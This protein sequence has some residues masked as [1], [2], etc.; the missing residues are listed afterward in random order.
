MVLLQEF[1]SQIADLC[2]EYCVSSVVMELLQ[3]DSPEAQLIALRSLHLV[4]TS[5]P[6]HVAASLDLQTGTL[7]RSSSLAVGS[8]TGSSMSGGTANRRMGKVNGVGVGALSWQRWHPCGWH[9]L[10]LPPSFG[11]L[12]VI[13]LWLMPDLLACA[14]CTRSC[15]L[16][17]CWT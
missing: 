12:V 13:F 2:P 15:Q 7:R 10:Q 14:C 11:P 8:S 5:V 17:L 3:T 6:Q 9:S 16:V 1:V 4:A